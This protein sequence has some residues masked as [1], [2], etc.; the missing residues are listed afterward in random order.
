VGG[1]VKIALAGFAKKGKLERF[2]PGT[3]L[4]FVCGWVY[5]EN[6]VQIVGYDS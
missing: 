2:E 1:G 5:I 6:F 3:V 4:L